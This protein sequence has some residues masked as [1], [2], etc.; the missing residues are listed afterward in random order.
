MD[1]ILKRAITKLEAFMNSEKGQKNIQKTIEEMTG[2][3]PAKSDKCPIYGTAYEE[4]DEPCCE[5]VPECKFY[6]YKKVIGNK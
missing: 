1:D 2:Y 3:K 5:Y 4:C 6:G